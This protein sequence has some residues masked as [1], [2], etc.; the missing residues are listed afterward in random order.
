VL[1]SV[2]QASNSSSSCDPQTLA[3]QGAASSRVGPFVLGTLVGGLAGA[4]LGTAL[5]P[6][7][8]GFLVGLYHLVNRRL[9]SS[10]HDQLRFEL[11]LQ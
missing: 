2:D 9:V 1:L 10:E 5:S 6:H 4:V 11:L 7:T 8:R 3:T